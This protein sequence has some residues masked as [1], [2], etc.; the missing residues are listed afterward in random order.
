MKIDEVKKIKTLTEESE[1]NEFLSRGY[2]IIKI[3]ST[4][5]STEMGETVEPTF[6]L[7]IGKE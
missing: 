7:G 4:K 5:R 3:F 1:I 6:I 2:K